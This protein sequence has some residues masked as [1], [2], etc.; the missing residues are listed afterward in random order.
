[1]S[2]LKNT[3]MMYEP[4]DLK[5]EF[6]LLEDILQTFARERLDAPLQQRLR[7]LLLQDII[8]RLAVAEGER[9]GTARHRGSGWAG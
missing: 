5:R 6:G 9:C 8:L 3:V 1:L 7:D 2:E 4:D